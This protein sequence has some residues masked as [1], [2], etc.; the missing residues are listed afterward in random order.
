MCS[1][2]ASMTPCFTLL[3]LGKACPAMMSACLSTPRN[4]GARISTVGTA[5]AARVSTSASRPRTGCRSASSS[6]QLTRN[7]MTTNPPVRCTEKTPTSASTATGMRSR[8][9]SVEAINTNV[10]HRDPVGRQVGHRGDAELD[11]G[12]RGERR[13]QRRRGGRRSRGAPLAGDGAGE[14]PGEDRRAGRKQPDRRRHRTHG[15]AGGG[16]RPGELAV[17]RGQGVE[18]RR[19]VQRLVG[20]D[21]AELAHVGRRRLAGV[22]DEAHR[23]GVPD[24]VPGAGDGLPVHDAALGRPPDQQG[25]QQHPGR[26]RQRRPAADPAGFSLGVAVAGKQQLQTRHQH[27]HRGERGQRRPTVPRDSEGA[28]RNDRQR[29]HAVGQRRG[30]LRWRSAK[31]AG[32]YVR[33]L[34]RARSAKTVRS[35]FRSPAPLD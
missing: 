14:E 6:H 16:C 4:C 15:V 25:A 32:R 9:R 31:L 26:H 23:V 10:G 29:H 2:S 8:C 35:A 13:R 12:H 22:E 27:A 21:V 7:R 17:H 11:V 5:T 19:V 3:K 1:S 33:R 30:Q 34:P 20:F 28:E 24:R 18:H